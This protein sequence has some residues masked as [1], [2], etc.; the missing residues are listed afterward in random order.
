MEI[1]DAVRNDEVVRL[2]ED[3]RSVIIL[4]QTQL[5]N[6]TI[7]LT[8]TNEQEMWDAIKLLQVRGAPVICHV[9]ACPQ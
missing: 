2:S 5:P 4:D 1:S 8:L 3:E 7:D 6:H 9:C